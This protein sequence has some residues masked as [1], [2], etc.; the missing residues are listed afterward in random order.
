MFFS[1]VGSNALV[2]QSLQN[3]DAL[4]AVDG[5]EGIQILDAESFL[6]NLGADGWWQD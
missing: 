6:N 3:M 5:L 2:G 1:L 4:R